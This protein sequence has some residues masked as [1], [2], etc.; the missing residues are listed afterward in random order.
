M[1]PGVRRL[2]GKAVKFVLIPVGLL[3]LGYLVLGP[4]AV[5]YFDAAGA[6]Q[7]S[8]TATQQA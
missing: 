1:T 4:F 3:L 6:R 7:Q 2:I 8:P 5:R